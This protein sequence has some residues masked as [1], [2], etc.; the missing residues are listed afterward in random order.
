MTAVAQERAA[1]Q[2]PEG[3]AKPPGDYLCWDDYMRDATQTAVRRNDDEAQRGL[4]AMRL[5]PSL[6][7]YRALLDGQKVPAA[8]LDQR[9]RRRYGL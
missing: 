9:W 3:V 8:A 2:S 7:V 4:K 1:G 6:H 5:A